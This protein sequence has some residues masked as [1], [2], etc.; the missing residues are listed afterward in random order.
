MPFQRDPVALG[1]VRDVDG[2]E[3]PKAE[4]RDPL[5]P[6]GLVAGS[7]WRRRQTETRQAT[8]G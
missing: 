2:E 6:L 4:R 3:E 8:V 7:H 1:E 5:L